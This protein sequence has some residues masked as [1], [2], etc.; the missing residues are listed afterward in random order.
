MGKKLAEAEQ[1]TERTER[2]LQKLRK[3][4]KG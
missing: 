3:K 4:T 1:E 2:V